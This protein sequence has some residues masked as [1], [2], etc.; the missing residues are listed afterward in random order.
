M[1]RGSVVFATRFFLAGNHIS[2][3]QR[4]KERESRRKAKEHM[5]L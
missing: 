2:F 4:D 3:E 1:A 5:R